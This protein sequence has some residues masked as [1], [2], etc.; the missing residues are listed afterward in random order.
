MVNERTSLWR[1]R[2]YTEVGGDRLDDRPPIVADQADAVVRR[3]ALV[4]ALQALAPRQ[5]A[6]VVLRYF[7][8]MTEPQVA[9]ALGCSIGTVKSQAHAALARLRELAPELLAEEVQA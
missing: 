8:D 7:E 4:R 3:V 1:R 6:V 9:E 2:R 5:R